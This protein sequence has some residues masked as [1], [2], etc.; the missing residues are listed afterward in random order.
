MLQYLERDLGQDAPA[1]QSWY[2]H[3]IARGLGAV[4]AW[5]SDGASGRCCHG[6]APG[7]ADCFL[8]PQVYNAERYAC[9]L[10][11]YPNIRRVVDYCRGLDAFERAAP[12][13]QHDAPTNTGAGA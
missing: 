10:D 5:L 6:D 13:N 7:L 11:P 4:E 9:D 12:E 2:E 8:V 3:W 1:V